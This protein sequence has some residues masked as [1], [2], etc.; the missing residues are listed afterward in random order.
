MDNFLESLEL[1]MRDKKRVKI[2]EAVEANFYKMSEYWLTLHAKYYRYLS[3]IGE[4]LLLDELQHIGNEI[5]M[6]IYRAVVNLTDIPEIVTR[7]MDIDRSFFYT[8]RVLLALIEMTFQEKTIV[9]VEKFRIS[10]LEA[11]L[12]ATYQNLDT[13]FID[14]PAVQK[15]SDLIKLTLLETFFE[16]V[17][18]E[19]KFNLMIR[20]IRLQVYLQFISEIYVENLENETIKD[21]WVQPL[22][23]IHFR[24]E[25]IATRA[26]SIN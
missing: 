16:K 4:E 24:M 26:I 15:G 17:Y 1:A 11:V 6:R 8:Y 7:T 23:G 2:D 13:F 25:S 9:E 12:E 14:K 20:A 5:G 19:D 10:N 21:N 3:P 18:K 22:L